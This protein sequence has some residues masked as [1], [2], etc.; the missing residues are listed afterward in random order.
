MVI[1][2]IDTE[3]NML[4]IWI[5]NLHLNQVNIEHIVVPDF[6]R[7]IYFLQLEGNLTKNSIQ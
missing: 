1:L 6:L 3:L 2:K 5:L 7:K 4:L